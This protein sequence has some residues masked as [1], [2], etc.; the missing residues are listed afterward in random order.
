MK[1]EQKLTDKIFKLEL[2]GGFIFYRIGILML[3][4]TTTPVIEK[5]ISIGGMTTI[6]IV[7]GICYWIQ[8]SEKMDE[9]AKLNINKAS[10]STLI[11]VSVLLLML[12]LGYEFSSVHLPFSLG[13]VAFIFATILVVHS[14]VFK[15]LELSGE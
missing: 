1:K 8:Q 2:L 15:Q 11:S 10:N 13:I 6:E 4:P 3:T 7:I 14:C 9:R 12:G 5:Y